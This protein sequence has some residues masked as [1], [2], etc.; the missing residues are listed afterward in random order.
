[1]LITVASCATT[2]LSITFDLRGIGRLSSRHTLATKSNFV[3]KSDERVVAFP[4]ARTFCEVPYLRPIQSSDL[5]IYYKIIIIIAID[6]IL[7]VAIIFAVIATVA[8]IIV[9]IIIQ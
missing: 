8:F 4:Y 1:M 5:I 3:I 9:I 2:V 7:I 6:R